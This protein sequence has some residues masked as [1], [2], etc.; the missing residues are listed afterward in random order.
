MCPLNKGQNQ[1]KMS[2]S[3]FTVVPTSCDLLISVLHPCRE[4]SRQCKQQYLNRPFT[5]PEQTDLVGYLGR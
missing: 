1:S 5:C 2:I 4:A 3:E